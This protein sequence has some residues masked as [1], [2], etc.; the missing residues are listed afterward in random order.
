M[1]GKMI[2]FCKDKAKKLK[3]IKKIYVKLFF[4]K[5]NRL[6]NKISMIIQHVS[7]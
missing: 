6:N 2:Y 1:R 4:I 3:I 5:L 7:F